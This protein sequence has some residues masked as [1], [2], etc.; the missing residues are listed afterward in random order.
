MNG[1]TSECENTSFTI[2]QT[3]KTSNP[4]WNVINRDIGD[5][6]IKSNISKSYT[7]L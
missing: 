2:S 4:P 6:S 5:L 3:W 1:D 7:T